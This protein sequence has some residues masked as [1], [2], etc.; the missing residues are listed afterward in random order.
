MKQAHNHR[1]LALLYESIVCTSRIIGSVAYESRILDRTRLYSFSTRLLVCITD[2]MAE[3]VINRRRVQVGCR[4][5][6]DFVHLKRFIV[7]NSSAE[8]YHGG[9]AKSYNTDSGCVVSFHLFF[10]CLGTLNSSGNP[11]KFKSKS[12]VLPVTSASSCKAAVSTGDGSGRDSGRWWGFHASMHARLGY[13]YMQVLTTGGV[14]LNAN[15]WVF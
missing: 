13:V 2:S 3:D 6:K 1:E 10:F 4:T 11:A 7:H 12:A 14:L 15:C 9:S 8:I 5:H